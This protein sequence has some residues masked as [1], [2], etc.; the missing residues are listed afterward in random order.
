MIEGIKARTTKGLVP[1]EAVFID[2]ARQVVNRRV[3]GPTFQAIEHLL[4]RQGAVDLTMVIGYYLMIGHVM[5]ALDVELEAGMQPLMP[6]GPTRN[7]GG[8]TGP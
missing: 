3:N 7:P 6:E 2:Y 5:L 1:K 8:Q 4:G